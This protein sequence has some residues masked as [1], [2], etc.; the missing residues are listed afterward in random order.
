MVDVM[1]CG[2]LIKKEDRWESYCLG[3]DGDALLFLWDNLHKKFREKE[4]NE[5]R[6][7]K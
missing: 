3:G 5:V 6:K 7:Y 1:R 2:W 4:G